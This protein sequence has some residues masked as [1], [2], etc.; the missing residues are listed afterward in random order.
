[1]EVSETQTKS[2]RGEPHFFKVTAEKRDNARLCYV[3]GKRTPKEQERKRYT[4][5]R[6][7]R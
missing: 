1:M 3:Q 5:R 4:A 7:S 6:I 2:G